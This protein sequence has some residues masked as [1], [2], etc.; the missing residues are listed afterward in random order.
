[1]TDQ[2][3]KLRALV[4]TAEP[5][6]LAGGALPMIVVSGGRAGVGTTTVALNLAAVLSDRGERV[7]LVDCAQ[8][9]N[10]AIESASTRR[11][12]AYSLCDVLAG[13]CSAREAIVAGPA[14][15]RLLPN[16]W[17]PRSSPDFSGRAQQRLLTE[18][19]SL[20]G[21]IDLVVLDAGR[22]SSS[23]TQ[24][25]WHR[26]K[27][28]LLVTTSDDAAVLDA[29]AALK[30][31]MADAAELPIRLVVNQSDSNRQAAGAHGRMQNACRRFL[32]RS[33][34]AMPALP[35]HMQVFVGAQ[36]A[37]RVWEMPNTPF[38]HAALWLGRAVGDLL[39][40]DYGDSCAP[41]G[42]SSSVS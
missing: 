41:A 38:G 5:A 27:L 36:A 29:Y 17:N 42:L 2:A 6:A 8:Q 7:L 18:L 3:E 19:E 21:E 31:G 15:I 28:I 14:G 22:G 40:E 10:E 16:R 32:S 4:D 35:R 37:P 20:D 24:R 33:I 11:D 34:P 25:L 13:K 26:A 12:V 1:M 9:R 39:T 30:M 23:W